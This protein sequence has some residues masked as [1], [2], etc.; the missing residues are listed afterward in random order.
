MTTTHE[1]KVP[2]VGQ[3]QAVDVIEILVKVGDTLQVDDSIVTLESEKASMEIPTPTA[4]VVSA[5]HVKLGDKVS[6]GSH[7]L[8]I[9]S[10][11]KAQTDSV[12]ADESSPE[13]PLAKE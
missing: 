8:D 12:A 4:G 13:K 10:E 7:L 11:S 6:E 5:I 9:I 3:A 1:I 2:D